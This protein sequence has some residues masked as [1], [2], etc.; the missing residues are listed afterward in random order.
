VPWFMRYGEV[1]IPVIPVTPA[2][3]TDT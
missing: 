3:T 1:Q 2:A